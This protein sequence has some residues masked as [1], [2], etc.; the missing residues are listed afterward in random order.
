MK[1]NT[2][3]TISTSKIKSNYGSE[4]KQDRQQNK[5]KNTEITAKRWTATLKSN[6]RTKQ[7][8][9]KERKTKQNNKEARRTQRRGGERRKGKVFPSSPT[10]PHKAAGEP[11]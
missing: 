8:T 6:K 3:K 11:H 10:K 5:T 9:K 4:I 7:P 1:A 2:Y